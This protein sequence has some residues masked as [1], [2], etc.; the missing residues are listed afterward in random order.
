MLAWPTRLVPAPHR[1]HVR[2]LALLPSAVPVIRYPVLVDQSVVDRV[3]SAWKVPTR[4]ARLGPVRCAGAD[5]IRARAEWFVPVGK[6]PLPV[7]SAFLVLRAMLQ[8]FR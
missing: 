4:R 3:Q 2:A 6:F 5:A 8:I 7:H 1:Q